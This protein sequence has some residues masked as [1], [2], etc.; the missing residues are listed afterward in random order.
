M[1]G[2]P[3]PPHSSLPGSDLRSMQGVVGGKYSQPSAGS[4]PCHEVPSRPPACSLQGAG[5]V[6]SAGWRMSQNAWSCLSRHHPLQPIPLFPCPVCRDCCVAIGV[7]AGCSPPSLSLGGS[8]YHYS[9]SGAELVSLGHSI[10][11]IFSPL[12]TRLL[13]CQPHSWSR[14]SPSGRDQK[15]LGKHSLQMHCL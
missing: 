1:S 9:S 6:S 11:P 7:G 2:V 15:Q 12:V 8:G 14:H 3:G 13:P 4:F 5:V 10:P